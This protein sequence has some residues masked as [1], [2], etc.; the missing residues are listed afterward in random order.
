MS[1]MKF[2]F[3]SLIFSIGFCIDIFSQEFNFEDY[4][5]DNGLSPL[6][7]YDISQGPNGKMFLGTEGG[8]VVFD[9]YTFEKFNA[10]DSLAEDI[11]LSLM[12]TKSGTVVLGH[13]QEGITIGENG[14]YHRVKSKN[15]TGIKISGFAEH[16]SGKIFI[17]TKGSGLFVMH[18]SGL[19]EKITIVEDEIINGLCILNNDYL[20][21]ATDEGLKNF[22]I[23]VSSLEK[24]DN[25][26][27]LAGKRITALCSDKLGNIFSVI[28]GEG[29]AQ[30]KI[31]GQSTQT[32]TMKLS[33]MFLTSG[34][35]TDVCVDN[36][37]NVYVSTSGEG[38]RK[39]PYAEGATISNET[40]VQI[41]SAANGL[42]S[43]YIQSIFIDAEKNLW[44]GTYGKGLVKLSDQ[45]FVAI[46]YKS[47]K[48]IF[49]VVSLAD[50]KGK[51]FAA[52]GDG[53]FEIRKLSN[54]GVFYKNVSDSIG[55]PNKSATSLFALNTILFIALDR[56]EIYCLDDDSK[57]ASKILIAFENSGTLIN[58]LSGSG[59]L[60]FICCTE[61][62][63]IYNT[64][65]KTFEKYNTSN[66][67]LH[68][69]VRS[70]L[71]DKNGR[72]WIASPASKMSYIK[73]GVIN[74]IEDVENFKSFSIQSIA[75]DSRGKIWFATEGDGI[76]QFNGISFLNFTTEQGLGSNYVYS[77][78]CDGANNIWAT[79]KNS[80]SRLTFERASFISYSSPKDFPT[81]EFNIYSYSF[82]ENN[83]IQ[84]GTSDG[85]LEYNPAYDKA[86][87]FK[88]FC[89]IYKV[90]I[91]GVE[92]DTKKEINLPYGK[93]DVKIYFLGISHKDPKG[94][95][96]T[97]Q[98]SNFQSETSNNDYNNR[99]VSY[100]SVSD[101]NFTFYI[102][103]SDRNGIV[104]D[105][106]KLK[107][108][109]AAP[110]WKKIWFYVLLAIFIS[111]AFY[112]YV[113]YRT[114]KFKKD[115]L[116]LE[117]I[118]DE[119]TYQL[120]EE[121]EELRTLSEKLEEKN[122]DI[123]ASINYAKKIQNAILPSPE[124]VKDLIDIF[125]YYQPRNIVS[126]DFYYLH[127]FEKNIV[128]AVDCTGHGVP[129]ALMSVIA[130]NNLNKIIVENS[131]SS[132]V[133]I[134]Y[135][136][137]N[138]I[139]DFFS[140]NQSKT[141]T[142]QGRDG[143]DISLCKINLDKNKITFSGAA[144]PMV[145]VSK[146]EL[147]ELKG[148]ILSIGRSTESVLKFPFIENNVSVQAGDC[149]YLFSDGYA[150]QF[151]G[152]RD[153]KFSTQSLKWLL[154]KIAAFDIEKQKEMVSATLEDWKG[155]N[156]Q[157][158]D[159]LLIGIKIK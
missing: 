2:L 52:T 120:K 47:E 89:S 69:N 46:K 21:L 96:Y 40:A 152:P 61:G 134:L 157:V 128:A 65:K 73:D 60:L 88:P 142:L 41:Y 125:I 76:F 30:T 9:G 112:L 90:T 102:S 143:M 105:E 98:L 83:K 91:D 116:R 27:A 135:L 43:N 25:A 117:E 11:V 108:S 97:Y 57:K 18:T 99:F 22:K 133:E 17:S 118:I 74:F 50:F 24:F 32:R 44:V 95:T 42:K 35:F 127:R 15:L 156:D 136:L 132:P 146:N 53:V 31:D 39:I 85:V 151:G 14:K 33:D 70:A 92:Y 86:G 54:G 55:I 103:C 126:G 104:S 13:F 141:S 149:I 71:K 12:I 138:A 121:K 3:C 78:F 66:G 63:I 115:Q 147:T 38:I 94:I 62:L 7:I 19:I 20:V 150:D 5:Q 109:I 140:R 26:E 100:P 37:K 4:N 101:G 68:N 58:S 159:L 82:A 93:Y 49:G 23:K 119:Q 81:L 72:I 154:Q 34:E 45:K 48:N 137:N 129:G 8:V 158:D 131:N 10:T 114:R 36:N 144:R 153:K 77:V 123:I 64:N 51:R 107:I 106:V 84:F 29:V 16:N 110:F 139:I 67:L 75:E 1:I 148:S 87:F 111:S 113:F 6:Y 79:H 124:N 122:E 59:D 56:N 155:D 80:I 130:Y 28:P 145:I